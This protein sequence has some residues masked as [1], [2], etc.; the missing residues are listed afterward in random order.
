MEL[1][2]PENEDQLDDQAEMPKAKPGKKLTADDM[3]KR[4]KRQSKGELIRFILHLLETIDLLEKSQA[5]NLKD[6]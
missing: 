2:P 1:K 6:D 5:G 4:L 3:K